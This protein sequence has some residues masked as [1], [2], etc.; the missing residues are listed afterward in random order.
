MR[1]SIS[2]QLFKSQYLLSTLFNNVWYYY[3]VLFSLKNLFLSIYTNNNTE[4]KQKTK[5][6]II[7]LTSCNFLHYYLKN[8]KNILFT[9]HHTNYRTKRKTSDENH[10]K[11]TIRVFLVSVISERTLPRS[12]VWNLHCSSLPG[13]KKNN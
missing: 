1:K 12:K 5:R 2:Y 6:G 3:T 13:K 10:K 9:T 7:V 11:Y 8:Q 4:Q